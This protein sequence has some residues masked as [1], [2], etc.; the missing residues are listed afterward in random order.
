[1]ETFLF[2]LNN[3]TKYPIIVG[4]RNVSSYSYGELLHDPV[5]AIS[6]ITETHDLPKLLR[7]SQPKEVVEVFYR[8]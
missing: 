7:S 4:G 2:N 8:Q 5:K 1:M 6:E 3:E